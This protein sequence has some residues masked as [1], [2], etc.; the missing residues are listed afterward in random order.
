M[1]VTLLAAHLNCLGDYGAYVFGA[2]FCIVEALSNFLQAFLLGSDDEMA[3]L[4][5]RMVIRGRA[6]R[7]M[8][9]ASRIIQGRIL[10]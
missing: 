3:E 8:T 7:G 10:G 9:N 4:F 2:A 6:L 5:V 1:V